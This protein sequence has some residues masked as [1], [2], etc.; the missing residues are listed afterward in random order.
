MCSPSNIGANEHKST[1][2]QRDKD[3]APES[4]GPETGGRRGDTLADGT[5][6]PCCH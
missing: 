1:E 5:V 2:T 3:S 4:H 6:P